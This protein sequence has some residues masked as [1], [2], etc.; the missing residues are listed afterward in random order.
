ME[1][2]AH[3]CLIVGAGP[4]G[5]CAAA[6]AREHGWE[7]I[8]VERSDRIGGVWCRVEP[9]LR[10]LSPRH[11]DLLPDRSYPLG[12]GLRASAS[13]VHR[14][15]EEF[16]QKEQF[17]IRFG[18]TAT[19]LRQVQGE[20]GPLLEIV[21][22]EGSL[23]GHRI[24]IAT[25]E[26]G[27][28]KIPDLPGHFEGETA[29]SSEFRASQV[30]PGEH[31][32]VVGAANSAVDLVGRLLRQGATVTVSARSGLHAPRALAP[33]P[34]STL[35]WWASALPVGWLPP[36]MQCDRVVPTVDDDIVRAQQDGRI[37][38]I[39]EAIGMTASGLRVVGGEEVE[40]DRIVFATGFLRDLRWA[41]SLTLDEDGIPR[42]DRGLST[43]LAGVAFL[44]LPCMRTRRSGFLRG[45]AEDARAVLRRLA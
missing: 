14:A 2:S 13:E 36:S 18:M 5:L 38:V 35:L 39:G 45:F 31:I 7:P 11:R 22:E 12:S 17:D 43:E 32:I 28:P 37:R 8:V 40:A 25:G 41:T 24:V 15:L 10:C 3:D 20:Q 44:G 30:D 1:L 16:A 21:T 34:F 23:Q 6:A 42:H 26:F 4:A 33:Q 19:G 29:H 27:C 9:D